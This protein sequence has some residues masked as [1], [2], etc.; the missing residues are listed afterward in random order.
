M[1]GLSFDGRHELELAI[2]AAGELEAINRLSRIFGKEI[3]NEINRTNLSKHGDLFFIRC[4]FVSDQ[5]SD[6]NYKKLN[7]D[8]KILVLSDSLAIKRA[9]KLLE[10]C[11]PVEV[12]LKKLLAYVYPSILEVF[13]GKTDK[14][15]R[16]KLCKQINSW[17]LGDLL[18]RLEFD[19]SSKRREELFIKDGRLLATTLE[20]SKTFDDFKN[21]ILPQIQPS[22]VWDQVCVV[23][24]NPVS[25]TSIKER[26]HSLRYLRNKAAHPQIILDSEVKAAKDNSKIVMGY[27]QNVKNNYGRELSESIKSLEELIS[28]TTRF[29]TSS[30][31]QEIMKKLSN[32]MPD[33]LK[34]MNKITE[35][36]NSANPALAMKNIDWLAIDSE[37]READPE[38]KEIMERFEKKDT[39]T[40]IDDMK[41]ELTE[42]LNQHEKE[43]N[44]RSR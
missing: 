27:I 42:D 3:T 29:Y 37:M 39:K 34:N 41:K 15:S 18:D 20:M 4:R 17:N 26:L 1:A 13:D 10:Y 32:S 14:K 30:E 21:V 44:S 11:L 8:D 23:L 43:D 2:D 40:V 7:K 16:I 33:F 22:T 9:A 6:E 25:Y 31:M 38:F 24:E 5:L 19:I 35:S 36:I 28:K 12:Q